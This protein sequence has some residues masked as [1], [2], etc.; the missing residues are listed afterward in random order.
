[1]PR[2][3]DLRV[4]DEHVV[5]HQLHLLPER[6]G[7]QLPAA[8]VA[9]GAAV[10]DRENRV[11]AAPVFVERHHAFGIAAG[12]ARLVELVGAARRCRTRW[13]RSR[14][15]CRRRRRRVKPALP[16]A[17][18]TTSSASLL[19]L[20]F[21]AKPPS[22]PTPVASPR[23][24]RID[25]QRM[26][27]LGAGAQGFLEGREADRHHHELLEVHVGVG[28]RAAVQDVH[29]RHRQAVAAG[30]AGF[31]GDVRVERQAAIFGA[32]LERRHRH[33]EQR[34]GAEPALGGRAVERDDR[35]V[36]GALRPVAVDE[37][38]AISPFTWPTALVT[39]LP[40]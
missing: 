18:I 22:S 34:V 29:H 15:R 3:Q 38:R 36:E 40:R 37:R 30:G 25:A 35:V 39:P 11:L 5:A 13:P 2:A 31:G 1:M 10:L 9:F 17:S 23:P 27:D 14:G 19:L 7:Q 24:F 33:A 28:V 12:F 6:L 16:M 8:P 32:G 26:E 20:R 4:G 21:G